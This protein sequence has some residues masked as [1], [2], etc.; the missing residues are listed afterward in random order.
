MSIIRHISI[1]NFRCIE[2][3]DWIPKEGVNCIIGPGDTGKSSILDA[4]DFCLGARRNIN[5]T[6]ADF[7]NSNVENPIEIYVTLG[8]LSDEFLNIERYGSF[9]RSFNSTTP[10]L[11]DE[12]QHGIETVITLKLFV[13]K[14]LEPDWCLYSDRAT[15]EGLEKRLPWNHRELIT[16]TRLGEGSNRHF[17]W[18]RNSL[19]NKLIEDDFDVSDV[20]TEVS[21]NARLAFSQQDVA[22][23]KNALNSMQTIASTLGVNVGVLQ[24]LLDVSSVS[25]SQGAV[26]LHD[27]NGTPIRQLGTGSTRLL[28][29]GLQKLVSKSKLLLIDEVEFGLEPFRISRFLREIGAKDQVPTQQVFITTHSPYVLREL[30]SSQLHVLR[31]FCIKTSPHTNHHMFSMNDSDEHQ[32]TLRVCAEAFLSNKVVVCEGKTEIG[33]LRGVDA[34]EQVN[35]QNSIQALGV[36]YADGGGGSM[37]RRAKV[38]QGLGYPVAIFKDSDINEQQQVA[39]QEANTLG[40]PMF[41][42]GANQAT[43]QAIFNSCHLSLIPQLLNIATDRKGSDAINA[44]IANAS[45]NQLNLQSCMFMPLDTHRPILGKTAKDKE[46]YKDIEPMENVAQS[47]LWPNRLWMSP[48]FTQVICNLFVWARN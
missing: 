9:L 6:D 40:I 5:F 22:G 21:R 37:F 45:G 16:P 27:G 42:W 39:I 35:G 23:I 2:K 46:W 15:K 38:F 32:S 41:E 44:H 24:A 8:K 28:L 34:A 13:D 19:L 1:R 25:V 47:I 36:M 29:A 30:K 48:L 10:Q 26:S 18:G 31:R 7:Y 20:L 43:E 14:G 17:T 12:P 11:Y 4:I 33:L 3:L